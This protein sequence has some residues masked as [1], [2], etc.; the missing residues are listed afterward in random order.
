MTIRAPMVVVTAAAMLA[1]YPVAGL[2][3]GAEE[4]TAAITG[5]TF[6]MGAEVE[7]DHR[8]PHEVSVS[9]F[10]MDRR[11]VTNAEYAEFCRTTGRDLPEFWGIDEF[12]SGPGYPDHPVVGVTW[13]DARTFC[14]WRGMRL[15]TEA[16]WEFAARGGLEGKKWPWGDEIDSEKANFNPS[17]GLKPVGS[18]PPNAYGLFDMA[19]NTA[20]WVGDWYD[21]DFYAESPAENPTGPE[22]SKYRSVRGGGWHSGPYCTRVYRRLGLLAYWVDINVGF[23]CA[24]DAPD[25]IGEAP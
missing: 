24:A 15:P 13:H 22:K 6:F 8:P 23:R 9:D 21:P 25:S 20:E 2:S 7:D 19:G 1:G 17:E 4:A 11:E 3:D 18:Y 10:L 12:R 14:E 5:G 16:E